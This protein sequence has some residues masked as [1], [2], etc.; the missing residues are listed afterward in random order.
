M[1]DAPTSIHNRPNE[2][3]FY[4][5]VMNFE[6]FSAKCRCNFPTDLEAPR[7]VI[8]RA[9]LQHLVN[10]AAERFM[11]DYQLIMVLIK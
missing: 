10:S 7:E 8:Y 1:Y 6:Q 11:S 5:N 9:V 4:C 3:F 2:W